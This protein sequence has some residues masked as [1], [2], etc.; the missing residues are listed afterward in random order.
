MVSCN[1]QSQEENILSVQELRVQELKKARARFILRTVI[2]LV[3]VIV[4]TILFL[5]SLVSYNSARAAFPDDRGIQLKFG[6]MLVTYVAII[7]AFLLCSI[8]NVK[9]YIQVILG[10]L[11]ESSPMAAHALPQ[12]LQVLLPPPRLARGGQDV[13]GPLLARIRDCHD[14]DV[15]LV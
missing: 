11:Q 7:I 9:A 4:V 13:Q 12:Q 15:G 2:L 14:G 5:N 6:L 8:R 1:S 10:L 3:P